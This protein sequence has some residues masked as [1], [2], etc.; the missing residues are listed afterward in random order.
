[1]VRGSIGLSEARCDQRR[2]ETVVDRETIKLG[3]TIDAPRRRCGCWR[4]EAATA[5]H[6]TSVCCKHVAFAV[7]PI[8]ILRLWRASLLDALPHTPSLIVGFLAGTVAAGV[9]GIGCLLMIKQFPHRQIQSGGDGGT[10]GRLAT[11][12]PKGHAQ[13]STDDASPRGTLRGVIGVAC[14]RPM[15]PLRIG[16]GC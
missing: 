4:L 1:M 11:E 12:I 10:P 14:G 6:V 9:G 16:A 7:L 15:R 3:V 8:W 5:Q 13:G 2:F